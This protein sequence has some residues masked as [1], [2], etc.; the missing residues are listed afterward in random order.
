MIGTSSVEGNLQGPSSSRVKSS[1][2][3]REQASYRAQP[4]A[5]TRNFKLPTPTVGCCAG[6]LF[7]E[8]HEAGDKAVVHTPK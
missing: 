2:R 3:A 5:T 7:G 1:G 8:P 6:G 4:Q